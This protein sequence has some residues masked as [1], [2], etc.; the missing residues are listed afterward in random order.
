MRFL[1]S[2]TPKMHLQPWFHSKLGAGKAEKLTTLA[3]KWPDP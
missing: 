1:G 2:E 3:Y